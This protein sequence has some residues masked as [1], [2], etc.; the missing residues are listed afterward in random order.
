MYQIQKIMYQK[1]DL[2]ISNSFFFLIIM[3]LGEF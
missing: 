2:R 3:E 1:Y